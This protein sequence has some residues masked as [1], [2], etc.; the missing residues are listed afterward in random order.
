MEIA[1]SR[2]TDVNIVAGAKFMCECELCFKD[3]KQL[4]FISEGI[5]RKYLN[6]NVGI[7]IQPNMHPFKLSLLKTIYIFL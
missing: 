6:K 4:N 3:T 1:T 7:E 5:L 2:E